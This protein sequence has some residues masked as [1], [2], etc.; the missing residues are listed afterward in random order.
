MGLYALPIVGG[1]WLVLVVWVAPGRGVTINDLGE[2]LPL[3][4]SS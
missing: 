4:E 3:T 1:C 2:G